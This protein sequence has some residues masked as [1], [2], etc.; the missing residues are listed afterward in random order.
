M[1]G[2]FLKY[3]S[4]V[5]ESE[6]TSEPPRNLVS[7]KPRLEEMLAA[8]PLGGSSS[9]VSIIITGYNLFRVFITLFLTTPESSSGWDSM[10]PAGPVLARM[11]C[12]AKYRVVVRIWLMRACV[13]KRLS[14]CSQ[15]GCANELWTTGS[16]DPGANWFRV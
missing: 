14:S 8:G 10:K 16:M 6:L 9:G 12:V 11:P 7:P 2:I 15:I 3:D 4:G 13:Q 1:L 5:V